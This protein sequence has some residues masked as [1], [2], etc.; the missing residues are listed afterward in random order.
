MVEIQDRFM[1]IGYDFKVFPADTN[2]L[3]D[4]FEDQE[5]KFARWER[6]SGEIVPKLAQKARDFFTDSHK[7]ITD[8][9]NSGDILA[10]THKK[11][12]EKI[13]DINLKDFGINF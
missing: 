10:E 1:R 2:C 8:M 6:E 4:V 13:K 11:L 3:F 12:T 7:K 9:I 5:S